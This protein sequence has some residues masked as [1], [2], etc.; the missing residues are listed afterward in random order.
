MNLNGQIVLITGAGGG[1]GRAATQ[2]FLDAGATK[3]RVPGVEVERS[4]NRVV[5]VHVDLTDQASIDAAAALCADVTILVNN[6]GVN[7][8]APVVDADDNEWARHEIEVNYLGTLAVTRAFTPVLRANGGGAILNV[9][10]ILSRANHPGMATYCASK[11]ALFSATQALRAQLR[12][13]NTF[14]CAFMPGAVDTRL[15]AHLPIPKMTTVETAD[16]M[17]RALTNDVED[18]YPGDMA[19][20]VSGGLASDY[21]AVEAMFAE[22]I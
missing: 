14:V 11:A 3:T 10:S 22:F 7:H 4:G 16:A 18:A 2:A 5:A 6:A 17:I 1:I 21:K 13:Q 12:H 19:T 15:T 20:G 8:N 9:L